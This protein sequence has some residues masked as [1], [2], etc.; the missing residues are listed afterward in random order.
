MTSRMTAHTYASTS[1]AWR[2]AAR[3]GRGIA[4]TQDLSIGQVHPTRLNISLKTGD[5]PVRRPALHAGRMK[6]RSQH[7]VRRETLSQS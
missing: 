7:T 6:A 1:R 2:A 5:I 4:A 3:H